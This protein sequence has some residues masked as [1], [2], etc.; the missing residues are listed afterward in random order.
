MTMT[1]DITDHQ[2]MMVM[3]DQTSDIELMIDIHMDLIMEEV[4]LMAMITN[5]KIMVHHLN[6]IEMDQVDHQGD[7]KEVVEKVQ[8]QDKR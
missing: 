6:I 5:I 1:K 8:I 3:E 2:C 7:H 4:D